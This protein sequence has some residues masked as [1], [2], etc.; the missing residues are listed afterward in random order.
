MANATVLFGNP[1]MK[2]TPSSPE[3]AAL[4]AFLSRTSGP[5]AGSYP[6]HKWAKD[7][8]ERYLAEYRRLETEHERNRVLAGEQAGKFSDEQFALRQGT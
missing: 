2:P 7:Q 6:I 5:Y 8:R 4:Q 1:N 3:A